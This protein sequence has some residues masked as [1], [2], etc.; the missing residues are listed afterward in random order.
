M[1]VQKPMDKD[2]IMWM[3]TDDNGKGQ[4]A[5]DICLSDRSNSRSTFSIK[6]SSSFSLSSDNAFHTTVEK[7]PADDY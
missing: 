2:P 4:R 1:Q 7:G 3:Q 6:K 5:Q